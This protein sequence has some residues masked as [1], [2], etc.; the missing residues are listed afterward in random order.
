M[1]RFYITLVILVL[2]DCAPT[3]KMAPVPAGVSGASAPPQ[4]LTSASAVPAIDS[5]N[6]A[7]AQA[8]LRALGY[9]SGKASDPADPL[10]QHALKS[11]QKDQGLVED[12]QLSTQLIEKLRVLRA[13]LRTVPAAPPSGLFIYSGRPGRQALTLASPPEGFASDAPR[14]FLVPLKAGSQATLHLSRKGTAPHAISCRTGKTALTNLPLGKLET[15]AVDCRGEGGGDPQWHDLF[16][17]KLG[18][19]VQRRAGAVAHDLIAVRPLTAGWPPAVRTGLDWALSHA[20]NDPAP[21]GSL[22]WSSTA[23]A[24]RFDIKVGGRIKGAEAGLGRASGAALC[25]RFELVQSGDKVSYPGIAC[26]NASAN[27]TLPGSSVEIARP[28]GHAGAKP[29]SL[30]SAAN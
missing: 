13:A 16:S 12:G 7:Q 10:F 2:A 1:K 5:A 3:P 21:T 8:N 26:Q 27:W 17:T 23:V 25:R 19:V 28:F 24:P 11:F 15:V 29:P 22:Q 20:L 30:R 6:F 18:V 9:F 14:S 4:A